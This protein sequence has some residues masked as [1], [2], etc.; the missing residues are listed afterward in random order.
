MLAFT[1]FAAALPLAVIDVTSVVI[2]VLA[3]G[4][5]A[6][7]FWASR[8]SVIARY[9]IENHGAGVPGADE[10]GASSAGRKK[11]HRA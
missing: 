4:A 10:P 1:S 8:P 11:G 6:L 7:V 2:V 9:S 3:G 5:V